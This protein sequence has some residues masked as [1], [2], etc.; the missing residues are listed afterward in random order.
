MPIYDNNGSA[1]TEIGKIYDN[2]GSVNTEIKEVY[3]N[4]GSVNTLIFWGKGRRADGEKRRQYQCGQFLRQQQQ[5][6]RR[7]G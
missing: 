7:W 4:N 2:N 6:F 3:D 1:N 5:Q